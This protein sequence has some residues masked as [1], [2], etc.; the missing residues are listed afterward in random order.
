MR[1]STGAAVATVGA[2]ALVLAGCATTKPAESG[3]S[4][5]GSGA[6]M[7]LGTTDKVT[8]IDPAGSYDNGSF[9]VMNQIYA[10]ITNTKPGGGETVPSPDIAESA[11]FT[12]PTEFTVKLKS[13]LKF[14]NGH[15]LTSSDVKF[16]Y[17]RMVKIADPNGPASLLGN[18]AKVD[19]PDPTTVVFT[20]KVANDQTFAQVLSSPAGPLVDEEVFPAD[21]VLADEDIVKGKPFSGQYSISS[22]SKND[23]VSYEANP[24]YKG[25]LGAP[26]TSKVNVKH[27]TEASNLRLDIEKGN[28][29][30]AWRSLS[31][32]DIE[33]LGK[34]DTLKVHEGPGGEIRYLVFNFNTMPF[35]AKDKEPNPAKAKA[36]RQAMASLIDRE[37]VASSVFKNTYTPLWSYIPDGLPGSGTQFKDNYGNGSGK[38]DVDKAK[39]ALQAAGV[40]TPVTLNIQYSPDHYGPSSGDEYAAYK[41]Q[42]ENGGLF[43][44][45]LQ[46]TEWVQY[47]KDRSSDVYPMHQLG[48]FPDISDADNY[49]TPFFS[50]ESFLANHYD[51]AEVQKLIGEQVG[52]TD[53]SAREAAFKKISDLVSDDVSTLPLLQGKQIAISGTGVE[54]VDDTLDASFKFRLGVLSK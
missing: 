19:A 50:K 54:G 36:V 42:L 35:G 5:G 23:L 51:N 28:I 3:A 15:D 21:K 12:S 17:D 4:N 34:V 6:T 16:T 45:N 9:F 10:F 46:S 43:T 31:A 41:S 40:S 18:L 27:Y 2:L 7:T 26:A 24:E 11:D 14:A 53:K 25:M 52:I 13:G 37:A 44:V 8:S 30:V 29:D 33:S 48:W 39:A 22:W 1:K 32:T 49:L 38:P 47:S 20:L